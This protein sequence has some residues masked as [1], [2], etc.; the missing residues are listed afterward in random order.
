VDGNAFFADLVAQVLDP[1]REDRGHDQ[2]QERDTAAADGPGDPADF[3]SRDLPA[4]GDQE[5][6]KEANQE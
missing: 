3:L 5:D 4:Q 1:K 2:P 6:K